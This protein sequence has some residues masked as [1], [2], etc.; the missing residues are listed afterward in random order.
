MHFKKYLKNEIKGWNPKNKR[1]FENGKSEMRGKFQ[2]DWKINQ[3]TQKITTLSTSRL[4]Q[5][6]KTF[7]FSQ[8]HLFP[9]QS[10]NRWRE[11]KIIWPSLK[12]WNLLSVG[13]GL[14]H[15]FLAEKTIN[16]TK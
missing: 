12:V 7:F 10:E 9:E 16:F 4:K 2:M 6:Q 1:E 13:R 3:S 5:T 14:E 15:Y 8:V 11:K